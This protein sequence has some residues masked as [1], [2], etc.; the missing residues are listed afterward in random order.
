LLV[1]PLA[2]VAMTV[3]SCGGR[4]SIDGDGSSTVFPITEAVAE[5]FSKVNSSAYVLSGISGTSGGFEKFCA[6]DTDFN[7]ASREIKDEEIASCEEEDIDYEEFSVAY[8]GISIVVNPAIDFVDCLTV[9]ELRRIWEPAAEGEVMSW[10]DINP[11]FPDRPLTLYGAGTDSGTFDYFTSTIVGEEGASRADYTASEDDNTLVQGVLG[12]EGALAYFGFAY[13][14]Q[15]RERLKVLGVD[16]GNG[17]VTP[18]RETILDGSYEPLS[19]PLFVY[20][21]TD[22]LERAEVA[23]F[24][25]FYLTEG[26]ALAEEVG[27]IRA[28]ETVYKE[29]LARLP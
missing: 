15:N 2:V 26:P 1:G 8:D 4:A 9:E 19:R 24:M 25:R 12:D 10:A 7:N 13:Y 27:F 6:G 5:E 22:S 14:E 11:E 23:D 17:C 28:P 18:S 3:V 20:V 16:S 29:G 21:R